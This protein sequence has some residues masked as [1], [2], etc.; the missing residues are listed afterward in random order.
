MI[1]FKTLHP[2]ALEGKY[3]RAVQRDTYNMVHRVWHWRG[4]RGWYRLILIV[5]NC[6]PGLEGGT[7]G[8]YRYLYDI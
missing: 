4:G 7:G 1:L 3:S 2:P 6:T 8:W 5:H